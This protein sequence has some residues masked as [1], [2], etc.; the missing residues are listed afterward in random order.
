MITYQTRDITGVKRG[1][2]CHGVNCQ[3]KMGSGVALAIRNKW[4]L[5]YEGYM[6]NPTGTEMLGQC[7]MVNV[8][9]SIHERI[10]VANCYTQFKYGRDGKK[11]ADVFAIRTSLSQA[12][13]WANFYHHHIFMPKIGCGLGGLDWDKE[14]L[15]IIED[16]D[17]SYED[18][19]TFVC[20]L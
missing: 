1:I 8:D 6:L 20:S 13:K 10:F 7:N 19:D 5:A 18:V 11:Y 15:P 17:A 14:V 3:G 9:E 4:P 16:L 12:Y 2:V